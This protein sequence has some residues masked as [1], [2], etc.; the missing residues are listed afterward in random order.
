MTETQEHMYKAIDN[1][2]CRATAHAGER[3]AKKPLNNTAFSP[4]MKQAVGIAVVWQQIVKKMH[5]QQR[6]HTRWI[7]R[8]KEELGITTEHFSI[9]DTM[10]E[11]LQRSRQAF[12]GYKTLKQRAP[13]LS[14][15]FLDTL[16]QIAKDEGDESQIP[17][18]R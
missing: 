11:A 9:P 16:I 4:K 15:E 3:C 18:M 12:E 10:E 8:M 2:R 17:L 1:Q 14:E 5:C 13:E 6:I 7:I